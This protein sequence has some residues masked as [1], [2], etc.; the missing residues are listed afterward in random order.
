MAF[1]RAPYTSLATYG[2]PGLAPTIFAESGIVTDTLS[3]ALT[4]SVLLT[5]T[6]IVSDTVSVAISDASTLVTIDSN[7]FRTQ[8]G[9]YGGPFPYT[10]IGNKLVVTTFAL[11]VSDTLSVQLLESP[12]DEQQIETA[13]TVRISISETRALFNNL[14]VTDSI[15]VALSETLALVIAGI[16]DKPVTDTLSVALTDASTLGVTVA[17]TD[18]LSVSLTDTSA[19]AVSVASINVTDTLSVS[20]SEVA[21]LQVFSGTA[22]ITVGDVLGVGM[23]DTSFVV[24]AIPADPTGPVKS[25]RFELRGPSM[26]FEF[27]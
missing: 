21:V 5:A 24:R 23:T 17:T 6:L 7:I 12:V 1:T 9:T 27:V 22:D 11:D 13:D 3:V 15:N 2:G 16:V 19:L 8:I 18:T 26:R 4:E 10:T 25:I 20:V 14:G